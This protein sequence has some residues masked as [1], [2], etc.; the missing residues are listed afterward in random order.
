MIGL[1]WILSLSR[2]N[3]NK[4]S[5]SIEDNPLHNIVCALYN[6]NHSAP[7]PSPFF[8]ISTNIQSYIFQRAVYFCTTNQIQY[9]K[10]WWHAAAFFLFLFFY[11][12]RA[13][14]RGASKIKLKNVNKKRMAT[15]RRLIFL[16][17]F[18]RHP[19]QIW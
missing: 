8:F 16:R 14:I 10:V 1:F 9:L 13:D 11:I 4:Y 7:D 18:S 2:R 5:Y 17:N 12:N 19:L 15:A 6:R 3:K